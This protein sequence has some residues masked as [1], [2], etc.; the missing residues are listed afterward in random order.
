MTFMLFHNHSSKI[1]VIHVAALNAGRCGSGGNAVFEH[2][3]VGWVLSVT[4]HKT[5]IISIPHTKQRRDIQSEQQAELTGRTVTTA[6]IE[7][8]TRPGSQT[9]GMFKAQGGISLESGKL[10]TVHYLQT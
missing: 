9:C 10:I 2:Y 5:L 6:D 3:F 1:P 4:R 8:F 7:Q